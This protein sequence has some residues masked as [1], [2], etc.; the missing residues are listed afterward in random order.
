MNAA[1]LRALADVI[2]ASPTWNPRVCFNPDGTPGDVMG[3]A[4]ATICP[5]AP[6]KW[7]YPKAR[8]ALGLTE[9][10]GLDLFDGVLLVGNTAIHAAD[11]AATLRHMAET[12]EIKRII[13]NPRRFEAQAKALAEY[14]ARRRAAPAQRLDPKSALRGQLGDFVKACSQSR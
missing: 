7:S 8:D 10:E 6:G 1:R 2:E 12:G 5:D 9:R 11:A 3:H 14:R 13:A 4:V